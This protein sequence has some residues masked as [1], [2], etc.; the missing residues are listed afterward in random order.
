M[1]GQKTGWVSKESHRLVS[2]APARRCRGPKIRI[3]RELIKCHRPESVP[4][5]FG[6]TIRMIAEV[7][8]KTIAELRAGETVLRLATPSERKA[9]GWT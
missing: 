2:I 4:A 1:S 8:P 7:F 5:A 6:P 9:W 3:V